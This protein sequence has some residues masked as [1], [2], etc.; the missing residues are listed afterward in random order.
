MDLATLAGLG[1]LLTASLG[2]IGF[3]LAQG[4]NLRKLIESG[5]EAVREGESKARHTL[6]VACQRSADDL[7]RDVE[8]LKRETFRREE[9]REMEGRITTQMARIETKVD[10]HTDQMAEM[11]SLKG[12]LNAC[13][14]QVKELAGRLAGGRI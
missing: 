8:T 11:M 14:E 6:A 12:S 13:I 2:A 9:A 3:F 10:R 1:S 7:R 5:D 4:A